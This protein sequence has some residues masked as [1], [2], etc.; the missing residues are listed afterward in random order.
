[1]GQR[2]YQNDTES[3][4]PPMKIGYFAMIPQDDE[5]MT[6]PWGGPDGSD[7]ADQST[8]QLWVVVADRG[9]DSSTNPRFLTCKLWN[10]SLSLN[11]TSFD[12]VQSVRTENFTY[13]NEVQ[14]RAYW[15]GILEF[16]YQT[17]DIANM[18]Y[19]AFFWGICEQLTGYVV[20]SFTSPDWDLRNKASIKTT[21]LAGASEFV[22]MMKNLSDPYSGTPPEDLPSLNRPL[23]ALIEELSLLTDGYL[24]HL[25]PLVLILSLCTDFL[26]STLTPA[27]VTYQLP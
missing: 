23:S 13:I 9:E 11:I 7:D 24:R 27:N 12:D 17:A 26:H 20:S 5:R 14:S 16:P 8:N 15:F 21:T 25:T 22:A 4:W 18:M 19:S 10:A 6:R 1:M 2:E 3:L